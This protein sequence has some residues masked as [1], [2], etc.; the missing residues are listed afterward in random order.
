MVEQAKFARLK[1][2]PFGLLALRFASL[3]SVLT[4][5]FLPALWSSWLETALL[6]VS[7]GRGVSAMRTYRIRVSVPQEFCIEAKDDAE[8]LEKAGEFYKEI[9]KKDFETLIEP[10]P[11][12]D[13]VY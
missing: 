7:A 1:T 9:Y 11:G 10:L 13:D 2:Q 12:P 3:Q 4:R 5:K 6:P 8:A